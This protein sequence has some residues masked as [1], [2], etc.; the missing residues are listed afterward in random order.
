MKKV[1]LFIVSC[2]CSTALFAQFVVENSGFSNTN[3]ITIDGIMATGA[4]HGVFTVK[5]NRRHP[6]YD[7]SLNPYGHTLI[8]T[9]CSTISAI[10]PYTNMYRGKMTFYVRSNGQIYTSSG[11]VQP[12]AVQTFSRS[13]SATISS[14]L[15]KLNGL[16]GVVYN[17]P[18]PNE[19]IPAQA[20]SEM[21]RGENDAIIIDT[22]TTQTLIDQQIEEE[23]SLSRFGL[24]AQEV[25][26]VFP[27]VVRTLPDGTKGILYTDL[28]PVLIEGMKE[29]QDS[30]NMQIASL[31]SQLEALKNP[32]PQAPGNKDL[33]SKEKLGQGQAKLYQ[34]TPNPFN[35][36]TKIVYCLTA[37]AT[38]A[39]ICIY[40]L[41]GQQL[42]KYPLSVDSRNGNLTISAS[43]F[44]PGMYIYALVINNQVADSKRMTLTD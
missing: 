23:Q 30:L 1:L 34:N 17:N 3:N 42:K 24:L 39:S 21:L 13:A 16:N 22:N 12:A 18:L 27:E 6:S 35:Q 14:S 41:N 40:N 20:V 32:L 8:R 4:S 37:N 31:Q 28:I 5:S 15:K 9:D 19:E 44:M 38:T 33:Y 7:P 43:E 25:E 26:K 36:E 29:L 11:I 2:L 10:L